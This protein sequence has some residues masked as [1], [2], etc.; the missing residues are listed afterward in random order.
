MA[1][2]ESFLSISEAPPPVADAVPWTPPKLEPILFWL[3]ILFWVVSREELDWDL[4][5]KGGSTEDEAAM[6]NY[7]EAGSFVFQ[8]PSYWF[9][10]EWLPEFKELASPPPCN[11]V[12]ADSRTDVNL[13]R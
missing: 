5:K 12:M 8:T 7:L 13:G 4:E 11:W 9:L 1:A 2:D 6:P 10:P 3:L